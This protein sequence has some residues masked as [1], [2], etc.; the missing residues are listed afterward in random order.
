MDFRGG[1]ENANGRIEGVIKGTV[2]LM[3]VLGDCFES[4]T[5]L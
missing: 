2:G 4:L 5:G 1:F 3:R